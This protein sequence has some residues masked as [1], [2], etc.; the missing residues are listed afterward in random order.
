VK[1]AHAKQARITLDSDGD[2]M[3]LVVSDDGVG[4]DPATVPSGHLGLEGMRARASRAGGKLAVQSRPGG[5]SRIEIDVPL[6]ASSENEGPEPEEPEAPE[7][8]GGA[9]RTPRNDDRDP[10]RAQ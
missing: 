7:P 1:H 9:D 6:G 10:I 3:R 5:G 8:T 2:A 4:F